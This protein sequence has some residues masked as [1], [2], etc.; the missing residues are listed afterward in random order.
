MK[1]KWYELAYNVGYVEQSVIIAAVSKE[2]A[3]KQL[4]DIRSTGYIKKEVYMSQLL[5]L[6]KLTEKKLSGDIL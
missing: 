2:D 4:A 1:S 6:E 3:E 5:D